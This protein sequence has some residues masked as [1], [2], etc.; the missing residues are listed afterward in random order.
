MTE[1]RERVVLITG[2]S[3]GLGAALAEA[4][5]RAGARVAV[6]G[7]DP[8][9][10]RRVEAD[11]RRTGAECFA[12]P[13]DVTDAESVRSWVGEAER[14]WGAAAVLVNNASVL[15]PRAALREYPLAEW[16]Q[17]LDVNLTGTFIVTQAALP[18]MVRRGGGSIVN[19][20]SGAAIP[21][22][23]S[24]GAYAISKLAVEGLTQNLAREMEGTGVRVNAV[25]PGAMRTG[26]RADA[27]PE[28]DPASVKPA[29]AAADVFLWLA[30]DAS[31]Q[32]SGE[33]FQAD[34]FTPP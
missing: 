20:S 29:S 34:G 18:G 7:R 31:R 26:M 25:D 22:R 9:A 10:L 23:A 1:L 27:Y 19:V 15:G 13:V 28:E 14:R 2:G 16:R 21:P 8:E 4:F 30:S 24:W 6:C 12:S 33:R 32:V 11:V 17:T 3:R 5:G